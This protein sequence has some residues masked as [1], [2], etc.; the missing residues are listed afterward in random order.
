MLRHSLLIVALAL[1]TS[2]SAP[3]EEDVKETIVM[4]SEPPLCSLHHVPMYTEAV[5]VIYGSPNDNSE[6]RVAMQQY[7]P[8]AQM[9]VYG[10]EM[11]GELQGQLIFYCQTCRDQRDRWLMAQQNRRERQSRDIHH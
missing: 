2:C 1:L 3:V 4:T 8:N 10:G 6:Y 7:F 5:P 11:Y 9:A